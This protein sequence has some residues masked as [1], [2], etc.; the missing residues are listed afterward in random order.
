MERRW[1]ARSA[2]VVLKTALGALARHYE[3]AR[4]RAGAGSRPEILHWGSDDYR[5]ALRRTP[6]G[7]HGSG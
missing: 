2:K 7:R 5:P 1:P 4:P 6:A 3:P